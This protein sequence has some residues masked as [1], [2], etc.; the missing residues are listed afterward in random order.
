MEIN[1]TWKGKFKFI[2]FNFLRKV[3]YDEA[4]KLAIKEG[5]KYFE[6]SAKTGD[7]VSRMTYSAISDLSFFDQFEID[8]NII[9][10]ELEFDNNKT[11]NLE[12]STVNIVKNVSSA[13]NINVKDTKGN[14]KDR[15]STEQKKRNCGC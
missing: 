1:W 11:N 9:I 10:N 12:N 5:I 7:G 2:I 14:T 3:S 15:V 13:R 6:V 8:R 4:E